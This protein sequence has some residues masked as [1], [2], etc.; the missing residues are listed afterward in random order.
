MAT[1]DLESGASS[2]RVQILQ[3]TNLEMGSGWKVCL[4]WCRYVYN[5][6]ALE[7]GYRFI[8]RRP[9]GSL[10]AARGQARLPS[11]AVIQELISK[12][13]AEGWGNLKDS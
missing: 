1:N 9:D 6:G 10:Q 3:E 8:W 2:A 11:M 5:N 4:Q 12:A 7:T 13:E